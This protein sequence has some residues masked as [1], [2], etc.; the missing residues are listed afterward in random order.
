MPV[1]PT[2]P[3]FLNG[4][5]AKPRHNAPRMPKAARI[6]D[7]PIGLVQLC[8]LIEGLLSSEANAARDFDSDQE[9]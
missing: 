9:G 7:V 3:W 5:M 4:Q 2:G 6:S 1:P 8:R